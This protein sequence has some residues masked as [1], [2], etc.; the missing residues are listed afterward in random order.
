MQEGVSCQAAKIVKDDDH[1]SVEV[2]LDYP[3]GNV[4][5]DS[6]Q[7]WVVNNEMHLE[8]KDGVESFPSSSYLLQESTPRH[9]VLTYH[10][11]DKEKM[12]RGLAAWKLIYKTPAL[13][14][15]APIRF[16]FKDVPLP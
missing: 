9:A 11:S 3:D 6:F 4:K 1:W 13:V 15:K 8:T 14:V 12:K 5:L 7:S 10:F 2:R 16:S